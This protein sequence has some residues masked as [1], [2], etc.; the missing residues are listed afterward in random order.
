MARGSGSMTEKPL[1]SGTWRLRAYVGRDP[2]TDR[3]I[4]E[5]RTFKGTETAARKALAALVTEVESG[6]F[7]RHRATVGDLLD[8]WLEHI[9]AVGKARPKTVYEYRRKIEGR[10]RPALGH[11]RLDR[12]EPDSL[13]GW[14]KRWLGEGLSPSTVRVYHAILSAACRQAVKWGWLDRAPTDRASAPTPRSPV[15]KVPTPAQLSR[16]VAAAEREDPVLASAIAL[17]ALTGARRG[18]LAALR[19]SDINLVSGR[20]RIVRS[21]T[22]VEGR[23][24][25]GPTKTYQIREVALDDVG[26]KVLRRRW[27]GMRDLSERAGSPLVDDPFVLTYNANGARPVG[28][29]TITHRFAALNRKLGLEFRLHDLRHFSVSTLIAAGIDVRTVAERH[30]H[31][32]ATMTLN[33]YAHAFPETDRQAAAVL[34]NALASG[35]RASQELH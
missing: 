29:D 31:A 10:I 3:P 22:V 32:Q 33:R 7:S 4:Q 5:F 23:P 34:G 8:K 12:L 24:L 9:E 21:L 26:I 14:Y 16:L 11:V 6:R 15:M 17:A 30:G 25:E 2:V 20:L 27:E 28:P 18:E 1:G 13:D 19:W 35:D